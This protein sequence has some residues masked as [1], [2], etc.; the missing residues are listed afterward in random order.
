MREDKS[1]MRNH[2][3]IFTL[4][5]LF[6]CSHELQGTRAKGEG[7][8]EN[9]AEVI[10]N[11]KNQ[12]RH[13]QD[14]LE[15]N[16]RIK[17]LANTLK[18]SDHFSGHRDI[19][20]LEM[21]IMARYFVASQ[22]EQA[23]EQLSSLRSMQDCSEHGATRFCIE[24]K[25]SS[26]EKINKNT[27]LATKTLSKPS[28]L[29]Q[30]ADQLIATQ[31]LNKNMSQREKIDLA[32]RF[33]R[34][35]ITANKQKIAST[36]KR[37]DCS[38]PGAIRRCIKNRSEYVQKASEAIKDAHELL[39]KPEELE[40]LADQLTLAGSLPQHLPRQKKINATKTFILKQI[41]TMTEQLG[42][43]MQRPDCAP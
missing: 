22:I 29:A 7:C 35:Q 26:I 18:A 31:D 4:I 25:I 3:L 33:I 14:S 36:R 43:S 34:E 40:Q 15:D 41:T 23:K 16:K 24:N 5:F 21:E 19:T 10:A 17:K 1:R 37:P 30:L 39:A 32:A 38:E 13:M 2:K 12:L 6:A 8:I 20:K 42:I 27:Q 28:E 11:A 9:K